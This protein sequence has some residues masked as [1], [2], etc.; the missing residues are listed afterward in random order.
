[1]ATQKH[2]LPLLQQKEGAQYQT[3]CKNR[4]QCLHN[5]RLILDGQATAEQV[6]HFN[7]NIEHCL[8]CIENYNLELTIRQVLCD[9][10]EKK[11]VPSSVIDSIKEKIN[12]A[13]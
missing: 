2:G 12:E 6:A 5:L 7:Q 8:P 13:V 4:Q 10:I 1:M 3:E 9:K 11:C